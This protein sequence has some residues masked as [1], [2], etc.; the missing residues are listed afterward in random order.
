MAQQEENRVN[1]INQTENE[2]FCHSI[3]PGQD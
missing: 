2:K 1:T 3:V